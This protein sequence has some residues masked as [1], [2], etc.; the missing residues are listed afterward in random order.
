[1]VSATSHLGCD[2]RVCE[3]R[4][5]SATKQRLLW[6]ALL[7]LVGFSV[8]EFGVSLSSHSLALMAEAEHLLSDG[9]ALGMALLATY[10]AQWPASQRAPF[11]YGRFEILAG[12]LQGLGLV[13]IAV[14]IAWEATQRLQHPNAE[15]LGLP[16]LL[17]AGGGLVVSTLNATL[18]H[19]HSRHDLNLRGAFLHMVADALSAVGVMVAALAVWAFHWNWADGVV[20]LMVAGLVFLGALPLLRD[21]FGVLLEKTPTYLDLDAIQAHLRSQPGVLRVA[22]LKVWAIAPG[23]VCLAA[24]LVVGVPSGAERDRLLQQLHTDLSTRFGIDE[25]YLQLMAPSLIPLGNASDLMDATQLSQP[26]TLDPLTVSFPAV[27]A[28]EDPR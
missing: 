12:V 23:Q 16:M 9:L 5:D 24:S 3:V 1:M 10:L 7:L 28:S 27:P 19:N 15:V 6:T 4:R 8:V 20:S 13:A 17:T 21:S 14:W 26:P 11:G 25:A 2:P 22:Q 18:L